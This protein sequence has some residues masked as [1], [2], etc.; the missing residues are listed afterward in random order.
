MSGGAKF[1]PHTLC[2]AHPARAVEAMLPNT[3]TLRRGDYLSQAPGGFTFRTMAGE[4]ACLPAPQ[5]S[6]ATSTRLE[7]ALATSREI[8]HPTSGTRQN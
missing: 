4:P 7:K 8:D 5:V 2:L 6:V 3:S 1:Q